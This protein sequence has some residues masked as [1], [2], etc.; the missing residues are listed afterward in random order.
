MAGPFRRYGDSVVDACVRQQTNYCDISGET[1]SIRDLIDRHHV[2]SAAQRLK[3]VPFCGASSAPADIAV[4]LLAGSLEGPRPVV[5][6]APRLEGGSFG[7]G[8]IARIG[9][10]ARSGDA[11]R[12]TDPFLLGPQGREPHELPIE[13]LTAQSPIM[14][15]ERAVGAIVR[16]HP[17]FDAA[18]L[19]DEFSERL[20]STNGGAGSE[21]RL[22]FDHRAENGRSRGNVSLPSR[23]SCIPPALRHGTGSRARRT[24]TFSSSTP[25]WQGTLELTTGSIIRVLGAPDDALPRYFSETVP[26]QRRADAW[27]WLCG[28]NAE[29]RAPGRFVVS[30]CAA[31]LGD[32]EKKHA[33]FRA[34][35]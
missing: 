16:L 26:M 11:V 3:F 6:A 8:T 33:R 2:Q 35:H 25:S 7:E 23:V 5:K 9:E 14:G 28:C 34:R 20:R 17:V 12:E 15:A 30:A 27:R 18:V 29:P 21:V 31:H 22:A 32:V 1:A 10:A 24:A 4:Y 19:S 13:H